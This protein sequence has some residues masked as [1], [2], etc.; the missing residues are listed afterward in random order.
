MTQFVKPDG[1]RTDYTYTEIGELVSVLDQDGYNLSYALQEN[2]NGFSVITTTQSGYRSSNEVEVSDEGQVRVVNV[3]REGGITEI[4]QEL[5]QSTQI[6]YPSGMIDLSS[7]DAGRF[8]IQNPDVEIF[9]RQT[10]GGKQLTVSTSRETVLANPIDPLSLV[11]QQ[12][13]RS[14]QGRETIVRYDAATQQFTRTT[15]SGLSQTETID[16]LGRVLSTQADSQ[17]IA[18]TFEY[19]GVGRLSRVAMGQQQL[20]YSYDDLSRL[21]QRRDA[22][23]RVET[24]SYDPADRPISITS[25]AG[26]TVG[27]GYDEQ[28][29]LNAVTMPN[30]QVHG[31]GYTGFSEINAYTAPGAGSQQQSFDPD[32]LRSSVTQADGQVQQI[33]FDQG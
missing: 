20:E 24:Y 10:P 16:D 23:G 15:P 6:T 17:V 22:A 2:D 33:A 30:G 25:P 9:S 18:Q 19:D 21:I 11:S 4:I 31:L 13:I 3:N 1:H 29:N 14:V 26:R 32:R 12:T 28:G 5:D 7:L 8:G 27:L